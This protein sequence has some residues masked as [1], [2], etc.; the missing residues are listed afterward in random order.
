MSFVYFKF[1]SLTLSKSLPEVDSKEFS[2]GKMVFAFIFVRAPWLYREFEIKA[3]IITSIKR[4]VV[5]YCSC[6]AFGQL[7]LSR[8][9]LR[10]LNSII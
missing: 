6:L 8:L 5:V 3:Q 1:T 4:L 9:L 7:G 10:L 2:I